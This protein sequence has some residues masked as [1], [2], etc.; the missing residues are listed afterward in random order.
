MAHTIGTLDS[1]QRQN[2]DAASRIKG[3]GR[4]WDQA[5]TAPNTTGKVVVVVVLVG[6][7][8]SPLPH[9]DSDRFTIVGLPA[10]INN[11]SA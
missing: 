1:G 8:Q 7:S 3:E 6:F 11:G 10:S 4:D 9:V 5:Y 2:R